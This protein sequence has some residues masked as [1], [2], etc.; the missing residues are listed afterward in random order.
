MR[1]FLSFRSVA[2]LLATTL[3]FSFIINIA[4]TQQLYAQETIIQYLM[5]DGSESLAP[6]D[7]A[8]GITGTN[9][10]FSDGATVWGSAQATSW[11]RPLPYFQGNAGW[12]ASSAND[13]K[14]LSFTISTTSASAFTLSNI[15]IEDRAT[16][17]GPSAMTVTINGISVFE[18][19]V[20]AND[21][22]LNDIDL[23]SFS[24]LQ[25]IEN[26]EVKIIGWD[27]G[28]RSTTG[29]G[30]WR[31]NG[32]QVAGEVIE[33]TEVNPALTVRIDGED[34]VNG[35]SYQFPLITPGNEATT[36]VTL[37]NR[38]DEDLVISGFSITGNG[39]SSNDDFQVTLGTLESRN[40]TLRFSNNNPGTYA[41]GLTLQ[42]ND[43][44]NQTFI[45][46]LQGEV[47]DT[48]QPIPISEARNLPAG[49]LVTVAG[50]VTV[51]DE[52]RGPVYFQDET[53][54]IA[55][56]NGNLMRENWDLDIQHGDS[57]VVTG[58]IGSFHQLLQIVN[59]VS[60]S[61]YPEGNRTLSP[62]IITLSQLNS[63]AFES[64]FVS[65]RNFTFSDTG[66]FNGGTNYTINDGTN[67]Q[68]RVDNFTDIAGAPIPSGAA[69]ATGVAGRF[70]TTHQLLPRSRTDIREASDGPI[71]L[72]APPFETGA[73]AESITFSWETELDGHS[74]VCY[75]LTRQLEI[76]CVSN[77]ASTN[78]HE[79]TIS[80]LQAATTYKVQLRSAIETDTS[81]TNIVLSSTGSPQGNTGQILS[82]FNRHVDHSLATIQEAAQ[83]IN[84]AQQL[85]SRI[86]AAER[87]AVFAFYN[88]SGDP[89]DDI[90]SA[91]LSA[92]NRGVDIRVIISNH[93]GNPNAIHDRLVNNGVKSARATSSEQMHNKFAIFDY[94][95]TDPSRAWVV[96]SSWNATQDGT[97]NQYQNMLNIQDVA[98]ARAYVREFNQMWGAESGDFNASNARFSS[99]KEVVNASVFFIGDDNT[100]VE[101]YFSPQANTEAQI[102]RALSSAQHSIN[103]GLNL[104]TRR[105]ISNT[106][107]ARFNQGVTVRGVVGDVN[108]TGSDFEYLQGWADVHHFQTST[109]GGLLHH[110]YAIVDG[111][112][113]RWDSKVIT[114]SHNWSNNANT[115]N[116]ENTLIVH[117][118]RVANEFIQEFGERYKQAGGEDEIIVDANP[119][120]LLS[121][122]NGASDVSLTPTLVWESS[123][124]DG[125]FSFRVSENS[126][127]DQVVYQA[128]NLN[129]ME[130]TLSSELDVNTTYYWQV[131][132]TFNGETSDWT[133]PFS[134]TTSS[135]A[136]TDDD[137]PYVYELSQNYPNPFNPVTTISYE[138]ASNSTVSIVV[139]DITGRT[140]ATLVDNQ[141]LQSGRHQVFFDG[142]SLASGLYIYRM[143]T[144]SGQNLTR[145]M[146]LVK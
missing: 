139:Y 79:V 15:S 128:S 40:F 44:D 117:N 123:V 39:F 51:T 122:A 99:N 6:I 62:E 137:R 64:Q 112:N 16:N 102:N 94:D 76:G 32:I 34:V 53:A 146:M 135:T 12:A 107:L 52:F 25:N 120:A 130:Y 48:S 35:D 101:L 134:F 98:L 89:G 96:T 61:V 43:P 69:N 50:W 54:G 29:G 119:I 77:P 104:I 7:P 111:E 46:N 9:A 38:G 26:A 72:T 49:T 20:A 85:I 109:H 116:D 37:R 13:G 95:H 1:S 145:K 70:N 27:N 33:D 66:V 65:I 18:S 10:D 74:E 91:I 28:S 132:G 108:V 131:R 75:G 41:G 90:A 8:I 3:L 36:Q 56:Y 100:K 4:V 58:E 23:T 45:L 60:H 42:T 22:R 106:M 126:N 24:Q 125:T 67:G 68:L 143:Q 144:S 114:G 2:Q 31:L 140:V 47:L 63:G 84:F 87:N 57:L 105:P 97:I 14:H 136:S 118:S 88:I 138:L 86:D 115:R 124:D 129:S 93:T 80:G 30:Q 110:K 83:N 11:T 17:A 103:L 55:W 78:S 82:Y 113:D 141:Q 127:F 92:H 73:T 71:I 121:P 59:D 19:N 21:T 81:A 133:S 142:R 5:E